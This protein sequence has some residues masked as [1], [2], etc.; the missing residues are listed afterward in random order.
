[1][2]DGGY[3]LSALS[4]CGYAAMALEPVPWELFDIVGR[5]EYIA[6]YR[7]SND[8]L[9]DI[10]KLKKYGLP[11]YLTE[12]GCCSFEGA[13]YWGGEGIVRL[14]PPYDEE[15]QSEYIDNFVK[16]VVNK[17]GIDGCFLFDFDSLQNLDH[18]YFGI[19][20]Q[21]KRKKGFYKYKSYQRTN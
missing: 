9:K 1:M 3:D 12:F 17:A 15:V 14:G 8:I 19:V 6:W 5:N 11:I 18:R 4:R 2:D 16:K 13:D 7:S 21:K 10:K 20:D